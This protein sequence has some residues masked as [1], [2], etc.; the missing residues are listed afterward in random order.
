[1]VEC[2]V[3]YQFEG[4]EAM[5]NVGKPYQILPVA[6]FHSEISRTRESALTLTETT[7]VLT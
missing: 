1:M 4:H 2:F 5:L 3:L 6:L 7:T